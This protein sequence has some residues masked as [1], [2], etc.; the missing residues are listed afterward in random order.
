M[1]RET[2]QGLTNDTVPEAAEEYEGFYAL[3]YERPAI[4]ADG[5]TV[6]EIYYDRYYY[7]MNFDL[8]GGYGVEPIYARYGAPIS[9]GTPIKA[10][11]S[12]AGWSLDGSTTTLPENMPAEN[13]T[14]KAMWKA[15][16]TA[17][18]TVVFWGEN[19]DDEEYSYIK[20][21]QVNVKPGKEFTYNESGSLVCGQ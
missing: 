13:R 7:L 5:S 21:A 17:K 18:V 9:V 1:A 2:K 12:F 16:A 6:V 10:G 14:Y 15:D 3:L 20:S 8:D 11:Y 4:A 19:A